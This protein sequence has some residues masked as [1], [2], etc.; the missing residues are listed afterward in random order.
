[1]SFDFYEVMKEKQESKEQGYTYQEV[2]DSVLSKPFK[3]K[4]VVCD[5]DALAYRTSASSDD[6]SIKVTKN[7]KSRTYGT[8]TEFKALCK[9]KEWDYNSFDI[10]DVITSEDVSYCLGTLKRAIKNIKE[11]LDT[12][13]VIFLLGNT[14]N[15]RL[16]LPLPIQY[17]SGRIDMIRPAHLNACR[18]YLVKYHGAY[19]INGVESDDVVMGLTQHFNNNTDIKAIAWNLDKDFT[20]SLLP[21]QYY[22]PVEDVIYDLK[23]GVGDL[24]EKGNSIKGSGLKFLVQ[25]NMLFD[26]VDSYSMNSHYLKRYGEKSFYKDFKDLK[27]E[28]EVLSKAVEKW[29]QL[30]PEVIEFDDYTGVKQTHNWLSLAEL[31]FQACYMKVSPTDNLKLEDLLQEYGVEY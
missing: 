23:G 25:Q 7:S 12:D 11:R 15:F 13:N 16:S 2:W 9:E 18:E 14:G 21:N 28:K 4:V 22:H 3:D 19:L 20:Q 26:K 8:R 29:K 6:R 27:T 10:E 31:Y 17:K 1:M 30:L 24:F 5:A